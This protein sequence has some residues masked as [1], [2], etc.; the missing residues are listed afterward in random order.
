MANGA[1]A[2]DATRPYS[3]RE[4]DD[5]DDDDDVTSGSARRAVKPAGALY[6]RETRGKTISPGLARTGV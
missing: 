1:S 4:I 5:D 6:A 2:R 3:A